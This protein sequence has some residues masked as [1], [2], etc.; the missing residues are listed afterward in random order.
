MPN[1]IIQGLR[2][3]VAEIKMLEENRFSNNNNIKM[4]LMVLLWGLTIHLG[5]N[6]Y[7]FLMNLCGIFTG[8]YPKVGN[9]R[10]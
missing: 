8:V 6:I 5:L 2:E 9:C 10:Y 1:T 4:G 3:F 7:N